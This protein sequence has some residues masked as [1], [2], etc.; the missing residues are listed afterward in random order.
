MKRI[1]QVCKKDKN[2]LKCNTLSGCWQLPC[3]NLFFQIA[4]QLGK[5]FSFSDF[6]GETDCHNPDSISC[7]CLK[8]L[9]K[10]LLV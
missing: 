9:I 6:L 2:K 8:K 7:Y 3:Q 5:K 1:V 10:F 4:L